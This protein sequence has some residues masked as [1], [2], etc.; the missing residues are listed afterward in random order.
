[1]ETSSCSQ[2]QVHLTAPIGQTQPYFLL[3]M[4]C[5]MFWSATVVSELPSQEVLLADARMLGGSE[6]SL[7]PPLCCAP[8]CQQEGSNGCCRTSS[9][10]PSWRPIPC[11]K[12]S[13]R[14]LWSYLIIQISLMR[15]PRKT[16]GGHPSD[17][18]PFSYLR[19]CGACPDLPRAESLPS[20][21]RVRAS[22]QDE[23]QT[24]THPFLSCP[25]SGPHLPRGTQGLV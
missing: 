7:F 24:F 25:F 10:I 15:K 23:G 19:P 12:L 8:L 9:P 4:V 2:F 22:G 5:Y 14:S 21:G 20:G 1:M 17:H 11:T 16:S 6:T 18:Y 3:C 13:L